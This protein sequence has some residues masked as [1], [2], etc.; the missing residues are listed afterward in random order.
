MY[1]TRLKKPVPMS[2]PIHQDLRAVLL[3]VPVEERKGY[4]VPEC[5]TAYDNGTITYKLK[6]ILEHCG[7]QTSKKDDSG[8]TICAKSFH[9]I[10]TFCACEMSNAGGPLTDIC[11]MLNQSSVG[12][13]EGYLRKDPNRLSHCVEVLPS[14]L[15][16]TITQKTTLTVDE[17]AAELLKSKLLQGESVSEGLKRIIGLS[18]KRNDDESSIVEYSLGENPSV[19]NPLAPIVLSEMPLVEYPL[20]PVAL[21]DN[22]LKVTA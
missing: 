16:E 19:E 6:N 8:K 12:T 18:E 17:D 20:A 22:L 4:V 3:A 13:T 5:A 1:K 2:I 9:A 21:T 14:V 15:G 10:R 11:S 7:I